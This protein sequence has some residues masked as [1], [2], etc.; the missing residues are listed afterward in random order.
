MS[1]YLDCIPSE[2]SVQVEEIQKNVQCILDIINLA[3]S[4]S[5]NDLVSYVTVQVVK[6]LLTRIDANSIKDMSKEQIDEY[7]KIVELVSMSWGLN[8]DCTTKDE[9]P[10]NFFKGEFFKA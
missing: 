6:K 5:S 1:N 10:D 7:D 3:V 8:D 2:A 9:L 4:T